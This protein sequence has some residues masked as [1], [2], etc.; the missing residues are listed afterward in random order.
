MRARPVKLCRRFLFGRLGL[1][2]FFAC[3]V[4]LL[5][6][7]IFWPVLVYLLKE[8]V[9]ALLPLVCFLQVH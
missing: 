3:I 1:G 7:I 6:E 4:W 8:L 2:R 9:E 5:L